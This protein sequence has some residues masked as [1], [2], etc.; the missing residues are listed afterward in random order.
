MRYVILREGREIPVEITEQGAG[1]R[2]V[3]GDEAYDVDS[4]RIAGNLYSLAVGSRSYEATVHR[5]S[6]EEYQV[7]LFDGVRTVA[8]LTPLDLALRGQ[9]EPGAAGAAGVRAPM[10]GRV[11][12]VLV[13]PGD[14]VKKGDGVAV[15]EAMKMQNELTAPHDGTVREVKVREGD[16]VERTAELVVLE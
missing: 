13:K 5:S 14:A 7:H 16:S 11:V 3:L 15:V 6:P 12:R 4:A 10:P 8:L 9:R 2:V 1:Y